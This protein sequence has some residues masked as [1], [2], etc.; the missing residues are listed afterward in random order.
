VLQKL[1][2]DIRL[3]PHLHMLA[4]QAASVAEVA[5]RGGRAGRRVSPAGRSSPTVYRFS[6]EP[7]TPCARIETASDNHHEV[8]YWPTG[9]AD[10]EISS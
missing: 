1:R 8:D 5:A 2:S 6:R 4:L 3:D 10:T 7:W 9:G